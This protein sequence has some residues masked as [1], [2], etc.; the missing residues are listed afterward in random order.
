MLATGVS[1]R[2]ETGE[3]GIIALKPGP[4][5]SLEY[6]PI[7]VAAPEELLKV[8][9][10]ES[11][12]VTWFFKGFSRESLAKLLSD[13]E[14]QPVDREKMLDPQTLSVL[15]KGVYMTPPREALMNLTPRARQGIYKA[16][17]NS[18][19]NEGMEWQ[20][21]SK[22]LNT[23]RD[24]GVSEE[25]LA[26]LDRLSSQNG[27]FTICYSMPFVFSGISTY[28]EKA[29]LAG[30]LTQQQTMLLK[31]RVT[32]ASDIHA[33]IS[34]WGKAFWHTD[35]K[36]ILE[37][38]KRLPA[39]GFL[40]VI[41]LLP[42]NPTALL[43]NYPLPQNNL[44]GPAISMN[45]TWTAFNFFRDPPDSAFANPNYV[46]AKLKTEY[47]PVQSDPQFGDVILFLTP[48]GYMIHAAVYIADDIVYSKNGDNPWHP[49]IFTKISDLTESFSFSVPQGQQ[50]SVLYFRNKY[51]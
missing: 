50:L 13:L 51:Y 18:R 21:L 47:Y 33:L 39:G 6:L 20:F 24:L 41:E 45:C 26:L 19:E 46:L 25:T 28:E 37:S 49:W 16:L 38:I 27:K 22:N 40:D 14:V 34:Y 17:R 3:E 2:A 30:A 12:P 4:W 43:Y 15:G 31:L 9:G 48:G 7:T 35:V 8:R 23:F 11:T 42:P 5:G 29:R 1:V 10:I 36:S 32:P 44:T